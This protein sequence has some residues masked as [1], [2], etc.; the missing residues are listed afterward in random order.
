MDWNDFYQSVNRGE[1]Q[2][3]Y[4]FTGPEEL[5][6]RE[7]LDALRRALLP[8]GLEALNEVRLENCSAQEIIDAAVTLP[9]M[10]DRRLVIV[11]DWQLLTAGKAKNEDRDSELFRE[12]LKN[13]P[14]SCC[15]VFYCALEVDGRKKLV[16]ALKKLPGYVDFQYISGATLMKWCAK[17]LKPHG[18]KL[19]QQALD[20]MTLMA[21]SD[22]TRLSGELQKLVDY[23]ADRSEITIEDVRRIVVPTPE[24]SVFTILDYLLGGKLPNAVETAERLMQNGT[25]A[26]RLIMLMSN[27]LRL[28]THVKLADDA[29]RP[30]SPEDMRQLNKLSSGRLYHIRNQIR[31][32]PAAELEK[33]YLRCAEAEYAIKS[34]QARDKIALNVLMFDLL[35]K[36]QEQK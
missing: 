29:R 9:V 8:V 21:G 30:L 16:S 31:G 24:Y 4:L 13:A 2:S 17:R 26:M 19:S 11:R 20:E 27:Q 35:L 28:D 5:N 25:D 6:K 33:R 22:L 23:S 32:I 15:I 14:D 36:K 3:V 12:W 18:K 1:Y 10:C 7:A 34:G